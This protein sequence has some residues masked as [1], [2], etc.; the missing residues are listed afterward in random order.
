[1]PLTALQP[2][3]SLVVLEADHLLLGQ[4]LLLSKSF[5]SSLSEF[6]LSQLGPGLPGRPLCKSLL[7]GTGVACPVPVW[8]WGDGLGAERKCLPQGILGDFSLFLSHCCFQ[9]VYVGQG[10]RGWGRWRAGSQGRP[11]LDADTY[12]FTHSL[13]PDRSAVIHR[14]THSDK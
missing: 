12:T 14:D 3:Q 11:E 2:I 8:G 9:E 13:L 7:E 6:P 10:C 5:F 1:M 4:N